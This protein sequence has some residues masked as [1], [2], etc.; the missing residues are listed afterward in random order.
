MGFDTLLFVKPPGTADCADETVFPPVIV[1][2]AEAEKFSGF[3]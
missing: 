1:D 2:A 3:L